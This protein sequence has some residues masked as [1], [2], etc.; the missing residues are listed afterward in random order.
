VTA[1]N[2]I[3]SASPKS[4]RVPPS[5]R[6]GAVETLQ[7][8]LS[9]VLRIRPPPFGALSSFFS[10]SA[11]FGSSSVASGVGGMS[12]GSRDP[13]STPASSVQ[14]AGAPFSKPPMGARARR[15]SAASMPTCPS[16]MLARVSSW[17][18]LTIFRCESS[19]AWLDCLV[20][21]RFRSSPRRHRFSRSVSR[22]RVRRHR[23]VA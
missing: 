16:P 12:A 11:G 20:S 21:S 7:P 22:A 1:A 13:A 23:T 14:L 10:S 17:V 19:A 2:A 15:F 3:V 6:D 9:L 4:A 18:G 5:V 8:P